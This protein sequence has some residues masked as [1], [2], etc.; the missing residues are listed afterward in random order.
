MKKPRVHGGNPL[1]S[2]FSQRL[3]AAMER[4]GLNALSL[5]RKMGYTIGDNG[6][7]GKSCSTIS[8]WLHGRSHPNLPAF[9]DLCSILGVSPDYLLGWTDAAPPQAIPPHII[10]NPESAV[11]QIKQLT[12][13][14]VVRLK[15]ASRGN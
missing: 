2:V 1:P 3:F 14:R 13:P 7:G 8:C 5:G 12:Q 4:A 15:E 6:R 11:S 10:S 9:Q